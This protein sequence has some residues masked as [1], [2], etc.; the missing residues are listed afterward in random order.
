MDASR[1]I[2]EFVWMSRNLFRLLQAEGESLS[3][4]DLHV[5][6]TQL[7]ILQTE[8]VSLELENQQKTSARRSALPPNELASLWRMSRHEV[9]FYKDDHTWMESVVPFVK[10]GLDLYETVIVVATPRHSEALQFALYPADFQNERLLFFDAAEL[11]SRFVVKGWPSKSQFLDVLS[12]ILEKTSRK[13]RVR[14]FVE[15]AS[16]LWGE[17]KTGAAMR[18]EELWNTLGTLYEY[19]IVCVYPQE[20]FAGEDGRQHQLDICK[21]HGHA[22]IR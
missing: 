18:L 15:M 21:L 8:V 7:H 3:K 2:S 16:L 19:S 9:E 1:A 6:R 12:P 22:H 5:L 17:G 4:L 13:G 10:V 20:E 11:L 14:I